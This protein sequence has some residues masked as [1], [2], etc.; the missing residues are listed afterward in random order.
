LPAA[1]GNGIYIIEEA[2]VNILEEIVQ[3]NRIDK[4]DLLRLEGELFFEGAKRRASYERF[5]VLLFLST[6]IATFGVLADSA[7]TVIGAM[8][9]APLMLPIMATAA[10]MVMGN[11]PRA[12]RSLLVVALGIAGVIGIAFVSSFF[13]AGVISFSGNT[14]IVSRISPSAKDLVIA[15]ACGAAGAFCMSRKDIANSLPGVAISISLVPP[16]CV[17]GIGLSEQ[18]WAVAAGSMLLFLTNFLS[19]LLAGGGMLALLGLNAAAR[20]RVPGEGQRKAFT[21]V[22]LCVLIVAIPLAATSYRVAKET[23]AEFMTRNRAPEW[24]EDSAFELQRIEADG[25]VIEVIIAGFGDP[26]PFPRL[27]AALESDLG[28]DFEIRL[29]IV[30]T[31]SIVYPE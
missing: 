29:T 15:L 31:R 27:A 3:Q 22:S 19:I 26:P 14:Q 18:K 10:A 1:N 6:I 30:S 13:Q 17:V 25:D 16:L 28:S 9:I 7:A 20:R 5:A 11:M 4:E 12:A 24:L 21:A 2:S 23:Q 8:I